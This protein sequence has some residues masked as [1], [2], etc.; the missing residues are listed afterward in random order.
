M[1]LFAD[2]SAQPGHVFIRAGHKQCTFW[3]AEIILRV[4][5]QKS[6]FASHILLNFIP[7]PS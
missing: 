2:K 6:I 4:D 1:G 5:D 3:V 7:T